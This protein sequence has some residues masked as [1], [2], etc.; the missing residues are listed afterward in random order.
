MKI[1][2][3]DK[4]YNCLLTAGNYLVMIGACLCLYGSEKGNKQ[5]ECF[6]LALFFLGFAMNGS[7]L[8]LIPLL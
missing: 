8:F 3:K 1:T 7:I 5:L 6:G 4:T 2:L